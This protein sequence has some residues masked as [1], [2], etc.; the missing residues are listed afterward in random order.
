[1]PIRSLLRQLAFA[2]IAATAVIAFQNIPR[3]TAAD[4]PATQPTGPQPIFVQGMHG[5]I[6]TAC[7]NHDAKLLA[8]GGADGV[9]VID[10]NGKILHDLGTQ[11]PV[12]SIAFSRDGTYLAAGVTDGAMLIIGVNDGVILRTIDCSNFTL[13]PAPAIAGFLP[14]NQSVVAGGTAVGVWSA[15]DGQVQRR[16]Q[17]PT[18][19]NRLALS[20]DAKLLVTGWTAAGGLSLVDFASGRLTHIQPQIKKEELGGPPRNPRGADMVSFTADGRHFY[21]GGLQAGGLF[22]Y[23]TSDGSQA[24][25]LTPDHFAC[26]AISDDLRLLLWGTQN[27]APAGKPPAYDI[28][29]TATTSKKELMRQP[30]DSPVAAVAISGNG[31]VMAAATLDG[32]VRLWR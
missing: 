22:F 2:A 30:T 5:A 29:V 28:V 17:L 24:G 25:A 13:D 16:F 19:Q 21:G 9:F 23:N 31:R 14:D 3:A 27:L 1:M 7:F 8:L 32:K 11:H 10:A 20:P 15:A 18:P 26:G 6:F 4:P 12:H